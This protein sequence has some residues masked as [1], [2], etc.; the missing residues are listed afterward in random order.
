M[1]VTA[2]QFIAQ[3]GATAPE[4]RVKAAIAVAVAKVTGYWGY[5]DAA[6]MTAYW[7]PN[8]HRP[9]S[10]LYVPYD[11]HESGI[12]E[13]RLGDSALAA[14]GYYRH[15]QIL[16]RKSA[17]WDEAVEL[18][19]VPID[20]TAERDLAISQLT[21][22]YLLYEGY[23]AYSEAGITATILHPQDAERKILHRGSD[24]I[25]A[26]FQPVGVTSIANGG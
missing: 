15:G 11:I 21:A 9:L 5:Y 22:A 18:D 4:G 23:T 13:L 16:R 24:F 7:Y 19:F 6:G 1:P 14:E 8:Q 26:D 17:Y 25:S 12:Q 3:Y 10:F 20:E 2:E